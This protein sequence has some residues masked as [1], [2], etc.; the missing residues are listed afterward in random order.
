MRATHG[1]DFAV[2]QHAADEQKLLEMKY[3]GKNTEQTTLDTNRYHGCSF[4]D[5]PGFVLPFWS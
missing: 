3:S 4:G 1:I 2:E 5:Q